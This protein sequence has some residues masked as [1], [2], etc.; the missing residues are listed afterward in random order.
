MHLQRLAL[1]DKEAPMSRPIKSIEGLTQKN[2]STLRSLGIRSTSQLLDA[3]RTI[4]GR[5]EL[6][7]QSGFSE[8]QLLQWANVADRMRV[9]GVSKEYSELL[10][11]AGIDTARELK[12]RNPANLAKA[13]AAANKK[14]KTVHKLVDDEEDKSQSVD[15]STANHTRND[16]TP[17]PL[18]EFLIAICAPKEVQ[19]GLIGDLHEKFCERASQDYARAKRLYWAEAVRSV[20]PI[21]WS[22]LKRLG[23]FGV[24]VAIL[25][26]LIG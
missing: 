11:A 18:A 16:S 8:A 13:Y 14:R 12:Y 6:A 24:A 17:P 9:K 19:E 5:K 26:K 2:A 15:A 4:R 10:N 3:A 1:L 23:V 22:K 20:L 7:K 25:R 21:I